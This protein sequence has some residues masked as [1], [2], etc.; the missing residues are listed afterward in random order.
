GAGVEIP[1]ITVGITGSYFSSVDFRLQGV[2]LGG[3]GGA[4]LP[5]PI[6]AGTSASAAWGK[7]ALV[8]V[9]LSFRHGPTNLPT[10]L[11]SVVFAATLQGDIPFRQLPWQLRNTALAIVL[12]NGVAWEAHHQHTP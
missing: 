9:E 11:D 7:A 12:Y 10:L 5:I 8:N 3:G 4:G 6:F 1:V 2:S